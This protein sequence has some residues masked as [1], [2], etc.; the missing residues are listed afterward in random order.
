MVMLTQAGS[1]TELVLIR[2][3]LRGKVIEDL[4]VVS[5]SRQNPRLPFA[6]VW[7]VSCNVEIGELFQVV[8]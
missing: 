4:L 6:R 8:F 2:R 1:H 5:G 7:K 3:L